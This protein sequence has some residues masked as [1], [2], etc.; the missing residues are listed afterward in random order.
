MQERDNSQ[1]LTKAQP[2]TRSCVLSFFR[3]YVRP[4][5]RPAQAT[6]RVTMTVNA[7]QGR[8]SK[9]KYTVV[10][11]YIPDEALDM[12]QLGRLMVKQ[13]DIVVRGPLTSN[14]KGQFCGPVSRYAAR[15]MCSRLPP[16]D[17]YVCSAGFD[18]K[19]EI[20]LNESA[21][22]W[23]TQD[24]E[25]WDA[26]TTFGLRMWQPSVKKWVEVS[27][28]G[29]MHEV[30]PTDGVAGERIG[31]GML[32]KLEHGS[33]I[34]LSGVQL[35]FQ[36]FE[37]MKM[38]KPSDATLE[39]FFGDFNNLRLQCPV[40]LQT[41]RYAHG[42]G[43][44][45]KDWKE[46]DA[47]EADL[48]DGWTAGVFP[49]CGHVVTFNE[50]MERGLLSCPLCRSESR[51][52]KLSISFTPAVTHADTTPTHVFNPC[53]CAASLRCCEFWSDIKVRLRGGGGCKG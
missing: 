1:H 15:I 10:T 48:E 17:C 27:V 44:L 4:S 42:S 32:A 21:P 46:D 33:I 36:D 29:F 28:N 20:F 34:D 31:S 53:G 9:V 38:N 8:K 13:N 11:E 35:I 43:R 2:L 18:S 40:Q 52:K 22:K 5:V 24:G 50:D 41:I 45:P 23:R 7:K 3:S 47:K 16:Y 19:R 30:R 49:A 26:V 14:S 6:H 39:E 37:H 25:D 51:L 12:F